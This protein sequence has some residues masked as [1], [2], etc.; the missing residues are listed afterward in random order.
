MIKMGKKS[1]NGEYRKKETYEGVSRWNPLACIVNISTK[2]P[3]MTLLAFFLITVL[4]LI[5][6]SQLTVDT[7]VEG[8]FGDNPP[9]E[10]TR[11][12][13]ITE[14]FGEQDIVTVVVDC[15]H[16]NG[17]LAKIFLEDLGDSLEDNEWFRDVRYIQNVDFAGEKSILYLPENHLYFLLDS[18]A[19]IESVESTYHYLIDMMNEPS[20]FVS[21]NGNIYLLNMILNVTIDSADI[22]TEIFDGLYGI[23]DDVKAQDSRYESLEIGF[24][25]GAMVRDYEGDKMALGDMYLTL[26]ITFILI[27]VLLFISFRSISL[28][29]LSLIPLVCGISI[30][31]GLIYIAFGTIGMMTT[32]F[33]VLL[34]GLGIDFSIHLLTRFIQ[35]MEDH[36]DVR[37]AFRHT[38][39]NTGKAVVLGTLTTATAFGAL[40]FSD[41][42]AMHQMGVVLAMGLLVTLMCVLFVLPALITL[43]LKVGKLREKLHKRARFKVLG[44]IGTFIRRF[45]VIFVILL[46]V[47]G[48]FFVYKVPGT[49]VN[50]DIHE[51]EPKTVPSFKQLEKVK[52]HFNYSEDFLLCV[53]NSYDELIESVEGF[54]AVPEVM[55]VESILNYL[56]NN[57]SAKLEVFAQ[58][59][60]LR[61]EFAD[62]SW[63]NIDEMTWDDLS[64]DIQR[65]WV[66][67]SSG[68]A[69]FLIRIKAWG[70]IWDEA[71][72]ADLM[73]QLSVVNPNIAGMVIMWLKLIDTMTE[74]I[75][76]VTMF[77]AIPILIIV[78]IGFRRRN[79]VYAF[80][81]VI[82]V[83]FGV[84]GV[85]A[86]SDYLGISLN[87]GSIMMIPLVVGIGIDDGIHILHR[88]KEEGRGSV[89]RVVQNT[90]KAIFLTTFTT[91]LAFS[92][93]T[94][95][96]HPG[97]RA[98][99]QVPVLGLILCFL[100]AVFFLPALI[101]VILDRG[102]NGKGGGKIQERR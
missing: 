38:S 86:L 43:R 74:D 55:E 13:D 95:A 59:K 19:T 25:G 39:V 89:S 101:G 93:F 16:S 4:F 69:R 97:L 5:P 72:R 96:A 53:V 40:Y 21:E 92:S 48:A 100:A 18:N 28:P 14:E 88:Y 50:N 85:L 83:L 58:A 29:L 32:V 52:E 10:I 41:T 34:L 64:P 36:D 80:L 47:F 27:L 73:R 3:G 60:A 44:R 6:A 67:N 75:I 35:E 42:Q 57:Q 65:T 56:P 71:Y 81:S 90:G 31:A 98:M 33:A 68:E 62:I 2:R 1:K 7:S 76:V 54:S 70:N 23:L 51:L 45:A 78:Y 87:I 24:T 9:E 49:K 91:C 46:I 82:P 37:R 30:T 102:G 66:S 79:P 22:R 63:L 77:A 17:T 99:S 26:V 84:G 15:S 11:Y 8:F 94:V 20:Y 12:Q 61:P